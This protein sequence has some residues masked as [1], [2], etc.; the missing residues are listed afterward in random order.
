M[1]YTSLTVTFNT[2]FLRKSTLLFYL[3]QSPPFLH[4]ITPSTI[5][6]HTTFP[7]STSYTSFFHLIQSPHFLHA[8]TPSTTTFNTKLS[9]PTSYKSLTIAFNTIFPPQWILSFLTC[10][11][12]IHYIATN[13]MPSCSY[14]RIT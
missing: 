7:N 4:V 6:F 2:T 8:F 1:S 3:S 13:S 5:T 9:N 14:M 11:Y 10:S 12:T